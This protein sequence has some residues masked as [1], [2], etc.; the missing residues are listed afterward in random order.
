MQYKCKRVNISFILMEQ[1]S[2]ISENQI[3]NPCLT[4]TFLKQYVERL[5][6]LHKSLLYFLKKSLQFATSFLLSFLKN[7]HIFSNPLTCLS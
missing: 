3:G 2:Q 7:L 6:C 1:T 5:H 4:E